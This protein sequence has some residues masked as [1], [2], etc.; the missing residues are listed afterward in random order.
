[1]IRIVKRANVAQRARRCGATRG[2]GGR[3]EQVGCEQVGSG[4]ATSPDPS[5]TARDFLRLLAFFAA[6]VCDENGLAARNAKRRKGKRRVDPQEAQKSQGARGG[7][8]P[9]VEV[10]PALRDRS[11]RSM[12]RRQR[13]EQSS[14]PFLLCPPVQLGR[15][16]GRSA[17]FLRLLAFFAAIVRGANGLAARNAKTRKGGTARRSHK[18]HRS[19]KA[20]GAE[21]GRA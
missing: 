14:P 20:R 13:R 10:P 1:M 12:N 8:W 21:D 3:V 9:G 17:G 4:D 7:G 2:M 19:H 15:P 16:N 6:I 5:P 11:T 18:K